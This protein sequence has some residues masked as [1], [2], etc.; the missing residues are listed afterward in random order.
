MSTYEYTVFIQTEDEEHTRSLVDS[1]FTDVAELLDSTLW[2][3]GNLGAYK[4]TITSGPGG[5][6]LEH[7]EFR[8][9]EAL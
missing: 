2:Q 6:L 8:G 7:A 3:V 9:D 1:I 5:V 4:V